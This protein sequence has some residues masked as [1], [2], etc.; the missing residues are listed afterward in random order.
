MNKIRCCKVELLHTETAN[1][2][3]VECLVALIRT[4]LSLEKC[5]AFLELLVALIWVHIYRLHDGSRVR[6][7]ERG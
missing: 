1:V 6:V 5:W 3:C 7:R 4:V 2:G